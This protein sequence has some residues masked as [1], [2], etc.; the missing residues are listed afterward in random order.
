MPSTADNRLAGW[1]LSQIRLLDLVWAPLS[2]AGRSARSLRPRPQSATGASVFPA[3]LPCWLAP[4]LPRPV[5]VGTF[6]G[7]LRPARRPQKPLKRALA[8]LAAA[9]AP[10]RVR[11]LS[12]RALPPGLGQVTGIGRDPA[13]ALARL[14]SADGPPTNRDFSRRRNGAQ[15]AAERDRRRGRLVLAYTAAPGR[16]PADHTSAFGVTIS[17]PRPP[18]MVNS[19]MPWLCGDRLYE[20]GRR[21]SPGIS[22]RA[23]EAGL[24]TA[25]LPSRPS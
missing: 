24:T 11:R 4:Y 22:W 2:A 19:V 13:G 8:E 10:Y 5:S 15:L 23:L 20:D 21:R 16:A 1:D 9:R 3:L 25:N 7:L 12:R 14:F 18:P 6:V 17:R